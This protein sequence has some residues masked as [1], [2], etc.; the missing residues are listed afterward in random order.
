M[1]YCFFEKRMAGKTRKVFLT[2]TKC[3]EKNYVKDKK[4]TAQYKIEVK[5][6]CPRCKKHTKHKEQKLKKGSPG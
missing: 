3:G 2:C 1:R 6:F 5:K 4:T